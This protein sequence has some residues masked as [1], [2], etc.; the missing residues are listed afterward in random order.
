MRGL[1]AAAVIAILFL[2]PACDTAF[3]TIS[4]IE[5]GIVAGEEIVESGPP[6]DGDVSE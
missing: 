3:Q 5:A 6:R 2:L 4:L 1:A